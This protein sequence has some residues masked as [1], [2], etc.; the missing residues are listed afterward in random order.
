VKKILH[1]TDFSENAAKALIYAFHLAKKMNA[2]LV[3]LHV[4]DLP[5]ILNSPSNI[6]S[7]SEMEEAHVENFVEQL[8]KYTTSHLGNLTSE[9]SIDHKV[10]LHSSR[11]KGI[12][13]FAQE[14]ETELIVIG[15]KGESQ[16]TEFILGSTAKELV[17]KAHCPVFI[18]PPQAVYSGI[19]HVVYAS[20]YEI[21]D[22]YVLQIMAK[23]NIIK[24]AVV[25]LLHVFP[26]NTKMETE[27][28]S[29]KKNIITQLKDKSINVDELEGQNIYETINS[30][31]NE[32]QIDLLVMLERKHESI[33]EKMFHKDIAQYSATHSSVP[34]L[35]YNQRYLKRE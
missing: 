25:K 35:S 19:N 34:V 11:T 6:S 22:S 10:K 33:L 7:F 32:N 23:S 9:L 12:L 30:Y 18:V 17:R 27:L 4:G 16:F 28:S 15:M 29:N 20:D 26:S 3:V 5:T 13:Q 1:P 21:D 2:K 8:K 31:I 24:D 14:T